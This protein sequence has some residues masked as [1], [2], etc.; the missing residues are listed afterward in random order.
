[1]IKEYN[2][3]AAQDWVEYFDKIFKIIESEIII[4]ALKV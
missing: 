1:M 4:G 3:T 2:F